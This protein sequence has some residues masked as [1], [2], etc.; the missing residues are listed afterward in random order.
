MNVVDGA[1]MEQEDSPST[2]PT[3]GEK[4]CKGSRASD[5]HKDYSSQCI[6][7]AYNTFN[8]RRNLTSADA[9]GPLGPRQYRRGVKSS[10]RRETDV[11]GDLL[12]GQFG[13]VTEP[14]L[15]HRRLRV[16]RAHPALLLFDRHRLVETKC[17]RVL[18]L[19]RTEIPL[20]SRRKDRSLV[21]GRSARNEPNSNRRD[22]GADAEPRIGL[23]PCSNR[24]RS[25]KGTRAAP[26]PVGNQ[27]RTY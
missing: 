23:P 19:R 22:A 11:P 6:P 4:Y 25:R 5:P 21:Q 15:L 17:D 8:V 12:R 27:I 2:S 1:T 26:V 9:P 7:A 3:K 14:K 18:E 16:D 24:H 10:P 20:S 13:N